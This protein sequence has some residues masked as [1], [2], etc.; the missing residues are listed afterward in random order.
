MSHPNLTISDELRRPVNW[1]VRRLIY[2]K[3]RVKPKPGILRGAFHLYRAF[4]IFSEA[5]REGP[6]FHPLLRQ[7]VRQ[8]IAGR[9]SRARRRTFVATGSL[10]GRK[11]HLRFDS[12]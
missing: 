4:W 2:R 3:Y 5:L 7:A 11:A 6:D 8:P 10:S 9:G 1:A 12:I